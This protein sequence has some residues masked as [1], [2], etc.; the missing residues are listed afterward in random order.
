MEEQDKKLVAFEIVMNAFYQGGSSAVFVA[1]W[2]N[3]EA[4]RTGGVR[5]WG[6]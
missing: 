4:R 5:T 3:G 6:E 2:E 1:L